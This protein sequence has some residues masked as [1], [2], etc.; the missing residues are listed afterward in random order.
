MI[1]IKEIS[2]E[3][4]LNSMEKS[5]NDRLSFNCYSQFPEE[6]QDIWTHHIIEINKNEKPAGFIKLTYYNP[7]NCE[8][9]INN[10]LDYFALLKS[11]K[12]PQL[13]FDKKDTSFFDFVKKDDFLDVVDY[14][15]NTHQEQYENFIHKWH[16]KPTVEIVKIYSDNDEKS[17]HFDYW[18][19]QSKNRES[20]NFQKM[21]LGKFLHYVAAVALKPKN[22]YLWQSST[23]TKEGKDM[24][25]S[26][27]KNSQ[28]L[29]CCQTFQKQLENKQINIERKYLKV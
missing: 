27:E 22:L 9:K 3:K 14:I 20:I 5:L 15:R 4:K 8:Y 10:V 13:W 11:N 26:M 7:D 6:K 24:W 29:I 12:D 25:E 21:G 28:F 23:Q 16:Q 18:P 17:S 2:I 19:H 1:I